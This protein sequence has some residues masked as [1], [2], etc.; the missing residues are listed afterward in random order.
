[1]ITVQI[2][3]PSYDGRIHQGAMLGIMQ[4]TY[5]PEIKTIL[6]ISDCSSLTR[7][8]NTLWCHALND[9]PKITHFAMIHDD[10][11]PQPNWLDIMLSIMEKNKADVVSAISPLKT[12]EG[13]TSTAF[14]TGELGEQRKILS[15]RA[16]FKMEPTITSDDI[17]VNTGLMLVD[18]RKPWVEKVAFKFESDIVKG[19]DGKF[20]P[21]EVSEDW[22]F[23]REAKKLGAK[24]MATRMV[25]LK[26]MGR[27]AYTNT[28]PWGSADNDIPA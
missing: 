3:S 16:A 14:G 26:H 5:N 2:S 25:Q 15:I 20:F 21:V 4:A 17:L 22:I 8:F 18:M 6:R 7:V 9:R 19:P 10:I 11:C 28:Q 23:S 13:K 12:L 1:M 27:A 24:L